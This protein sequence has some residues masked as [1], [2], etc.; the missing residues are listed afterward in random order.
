MDE[1]GPQETRELLL[2][3]WI[4]VSLLAEIL[5][6]RELICRG[7]LVGVLEQAIAI[8]RGGRRTAIA[9]MCLLIESGF[10]L[11]ASAPDW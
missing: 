6:D 10:G 7:D 4:G 11:G 1:L 2:G 5:I 9:G 3:T 8:A